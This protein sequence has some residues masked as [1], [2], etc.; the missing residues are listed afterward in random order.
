[1]H[2]ELQ[3]DI[4]CGNDHGGRCRQGFIKHY[5]HYQFVWYVFPQHRLLEWEAGDD[6]QPLCENGI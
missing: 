2:T 3:W 6:W 5:Q 1:M 4:F